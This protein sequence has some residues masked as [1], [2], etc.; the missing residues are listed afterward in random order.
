MR[1]VVLLYGGIS[2]GVIIVSIIGTLTVWHSPQGSNVSEW[3]GYL[4]MVIALSSMFFGIKSYRDNHLGGVIRFRT[5][6]SVG[7]LITLVASCAYVGVWELYLAT[8]GQNFIESYTSAHLERLKRD[9]ADEERLTAARAEMDNL[10]A[11]Y[12][13]PLTRMAVTCVEIAPVGVVVALICSLILKRSD[14]LP[15]T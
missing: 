4:I 11:L 9:G 14:V 10:K 8:S 12:A 5:A 2:G 3:L 7:L 1:K 15:A 6:L 13:N